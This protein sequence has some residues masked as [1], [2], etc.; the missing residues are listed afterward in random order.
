MICES[1][2]VTEQP[3]AIARSTADLCEIFRQRVRDLNVSLETIDA[4]AGLPSRYS[5]KLLGPNPAKNFGAISFDALLG[6]LGLKLIVVEDADALARV[7]SRFVPLER[8]DRSA[9]CR[10]KIVVKL[11]REFMR[12]IGSLGGRKSAEI[13]HARALNSEMKRRAALARWRKPEVPDAAA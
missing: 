4:V 11:T 2:T 8:I 13:R 3:L 1:N 7:R 10:R 12:K 5:A 9:A 6:T